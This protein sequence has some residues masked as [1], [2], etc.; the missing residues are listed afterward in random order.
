MTARRLVW[1]SAGAASAVAAKLTVSEFGTENVVIAYCDTGSEHPDNARFIIDCEAW[2]GHPVTVLRSTEYAS[3][4][5]VIERR[6]YIVG[7][8]GAPC[9]LHLKKR[10]R[11][12]FER[13]DDIQVFGY[14]ADGADVARADRFRRINA[15]VNLETPLID[16]GLTKSDVLAIIERAEIEIPVMYL[17]G[18]Q[19]NNCIGCVKGGIGYWNSIRV[20]FPDVFARRAAQER[21][22][23]HSI[24]SDRHGPIWLDELDPERG[25]HS[26]EPSFDCSLLCAAAEDEMGGAA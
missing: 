17:L 14:T 16:R 21:R 23:G 18:Y 6:K 20:D 5:D 13:F 2:F 26:K 15:E 24:L 8:N 4:D 19:N 3:V 12:R 10:V 7:T 9:T 1:F 22:I 25:W 11:Q